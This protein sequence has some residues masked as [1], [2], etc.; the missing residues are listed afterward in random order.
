LVATAFQSRVLVADAWNE[1]M[2]TT[3]P[4]PRLLIVD[5]EEQVREMFTRLLRS[6][7]LSADLTNLAESR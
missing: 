2:E 5:D 7:T 3:P 6:R 1:T 4:T